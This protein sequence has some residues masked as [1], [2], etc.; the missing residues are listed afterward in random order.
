MR[1]FSPNWD[2]RG[3]QNL[4]LI[5]LDDYEVE[6]LRRL[7]YAVAGV[8]KE[9]EVRVTEFNNGDWVGQI[10]WYL[11]KTPPEQNPNRPWPEGTRPE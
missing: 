1:V 2:R 9:S 5:E 10:G 3:V 7:L 6:N 11:P 4:H 8:T